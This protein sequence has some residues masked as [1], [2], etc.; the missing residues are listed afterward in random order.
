MVR[1]PTA[2]WRSRPPALRPHDQEAAGTRAT[3]ERCL[4]GQR[5]AVAEEE[6]VQSRRKRLVRVDGGIRSRHGDDRDV[7][8][9]G[10]ARGAGGRARH[11]IFTRRLAVPAGAQELLDARQRAVRDRLGARANADQEIGGPGFRRLR[12]PHPGLGQHRAARRR[13]HHDPDFRHPRQLP[14]L[15]GDAHEVD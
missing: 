11:H 10:S 3:L 9:G 13:S 12:R 6:D 15:L 1:P 5:Y 2:A 7:G 14:R 8:G 4:V